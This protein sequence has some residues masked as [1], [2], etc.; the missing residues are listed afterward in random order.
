MFLRQTALKNIVLPRAAKEPIAPVT[1]RL[2]EVVPKSASTAATV[3]RF[4]ILTSSNDSIV[5]SAA[6]SSI[7]GSVNASWRIIVNINYGGDDYDGLATCSVCGDRYTT[8]DSGICHICQQQE[9]IDNDDMEWMNDEM[10]DCPYCGSTIF[11]GSGCSCNE[12]LDEHSDVD[13]Y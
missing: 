7:I 13:G 12:W 10:E 2:K 6:N 4:S 3:A 5:P 9:Q 11:P 1:E 8:S